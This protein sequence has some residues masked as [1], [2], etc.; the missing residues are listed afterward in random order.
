MSSQINQ[1]QPSWHFI[2]VPLGSTVAG[3][4][5]SGIETF[6]DKPI[7]GLAREICQNSLD[8]KRT[9]VGDGEP[10][11]VEFNRFD[12]PRER[13]LGCQELENAF[14][15]CV[16]L[17]KIRKNE[18]TVNFFKAAIREMSASVHSW[19][20][21]SDF[22]TTGL[23]GVSNDPRSLEPSAWSGLVTSA[24]DSTKSGNQGGSFGIGKFAP[25]A[26]TKIRTCFY[27]TQTQNDESGFQG[28]SIT[29]AFQAD[30]NNITTGV[31]CYRNGFFPVN[32]PPNLDK[33]FNRLEP[34]TDV[35]IPLFNGANNWMKSIRESVLDGFLY[36]IFQ[37]KL[38]V[39]L[40]ENGECVTVLNREW[41]NRHYDEDEAIT[42]TVRQN[43]LA[44]TSPDSHVFTENIDSD[45]YLELRVLLAP[46]FDRRISMI[47]ETGMKIYPM[48]GFSS[49]ISFSAVMIAHG[50]NLNRRLKKFENPQH[51][52]WE[53]NRNETDGA[54]LDRIHSFCRK[55]VA[56]CFATDQTEEADAGLGD[57]LPALGESETLERREALTTK[58]ALR[59]S[60]RV[61][62]R[63]VVHVS[64]NDEP[65]DTSAQSSNPDETTTGAGSGPGTT[66]N[67][68]DS[69]LHHGGDD[70]G[71]GNGTSAEGTQHQ[72]KLK[73]IE[74]ATCRFICPND[75][76]GKYRL[77][78]TPKKSSDHG[79]VEIIAV[80]ELSNYEA[81]IRKAETTDG[82]QLEIKEGNKICGV[83][84]DSGKKL[85]ILLELAYTD[86]VSMEV[87]LWN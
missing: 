8:A 19:L 32:P 63:P 5:H 84:F 71:N 72:P 27:S 86:Y 67:E 7:E 70:Q 43:Y 75:R 25:F 37:N 24:G 13:L 39:R 49:H 59:S 45:G 76:T 30:A 46:K 82:T 17:W 20:R 57:V 83:H 35:F 14:S 66:T 21:V 10:V 34:G 40:C 61:K 60:K 38:E 16:S 50:E 44:L 85:E 36:A 47:R 79:I 68:T 12:A 2:T 65:G 9:D 22:K 54:L 42:P 4:N 87:K 1:T 58:V 53:K 3:L 48:K 73:S 29:A 23:S 77:F 41:L 28:V 56:E 33:T 64:N 69:G 26:C 80:A 62:K 78:V 18:D 31:G 74:V 51:K 6:R 52:N 15:K 55:K 81:E 11:V